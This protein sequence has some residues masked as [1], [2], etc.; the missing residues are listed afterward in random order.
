MTAKYCLCIVFDT[1]DKHA[2]HELKRSLSQ[3]LSSKDYL[4]KETLS[5]VGTFFLRS[6]EPIA[7]GTQNKII[8]IFDDHQIEIL[9]SYKPTQSIYLSFYVV[10]LNFSFWDIISLK[11]L[12]FLFNLARLMRKERYEKTFEVTS[13]LLIFSFSFQEPMQE[14]I[15]DF[16]E[17]TLNSLQFDYLALKI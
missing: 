1:S 2:Y 11:K 4:F 5:E 16:Y 13:N 14:S 10:V 9:H 7:T 8:E 3:E 12:F 15:L 17:K 6:L